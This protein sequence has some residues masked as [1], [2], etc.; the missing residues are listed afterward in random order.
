MRLGVFGG[1]FDPVH[2]GHLLLAEC[3]REEA[4]LDEVWF[5]PAQQS[6]FKT[7]APSAS[8]KHRAEML[9]LA[10]AGH[11]AFKVNELELQRTG[12]SYTVD[13]LAAI[14]DEHPDAELF[15][16]MGADSLADLH[17]WKEPA[18][19]LQLSTIIAMNRETR[20]PHPAGDLQ[21]M[22]AQLGG[23]VQLGM[24]PSVGL[25]ASALR[26]RAA[27]KRSMRF[28]VPRAV[29]LYLQQHQLYDPAA[30]ASKNE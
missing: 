11:P 18:R 7:D 9:R 29:E 10:V 2:Y 21:V 19:I 6:P 8:G 17:R 22:V 4:Q 15:L 5:V 27:A 25:S 20:G 3:A 14:H 1:T 30:A 28:Q 16:I 23:G 13:T 12:P 24:M 26:Q